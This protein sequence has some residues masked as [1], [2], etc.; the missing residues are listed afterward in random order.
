MKL[1]TLQKEE[2][3]EILKKGK[4]YIPNAS[5]NLIPEVYEEMF[6]YYNK[7]N[8]TNINSAIWLWYKVNWVRTNKLPSKET[9]GQM[10]NFYNDEKKT[11]VLLL[12]IPDEVCYLIDAYSW[13]S[14]A[15]DTK[16]E[17]LSN[18]YIWDAKVDWEKEVDF[19]QAIIPTI[20]P[21]YLIYYKKVEY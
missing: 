10:K 1:V 9:L 20:K 2:V 17:R 3:I 7:I 15:A 19:V 18:P 6:R 11:V 16:E 5:Y 13:G 14:Y 8:G 4:E 12:E 21:E